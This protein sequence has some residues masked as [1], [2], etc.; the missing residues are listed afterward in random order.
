MKKLAVLLVVALVGCKGKKI[1]EEAALVEREKAAAIEAAKAGKID[2]LA[3]HVG[4]IEGAAF[5]LNELGA[6]AVEGTPTEAYFDGVRSEILGALPESFPAAFLAASD[7][8]AQETILEFIAK[9]DADRAAALKKKLTSR[10]KILVRGASTGS[11]EPLV[12]KYQASHPH[13]RWIVAEGL[14]S[15]DAEAKVAVVLD[16]AEDVDIQKL[17]TFEKTDVSGR[18]TGGPD[19]H[20][21]SGYGVRL[22]VRWVEVKAPDSVD[23]PTVFFAAQKVDQPASFRGS[24]KT[25]A[26]SKFA[27]HQAQALRSASAALHTQLMERFVAELLPKLE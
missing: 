25:S 10:L 17:I 6:D 15:K 2:G 14:R 5:R 12:K 19:Y 27:Q 13:L 21:L 9:A 22:T 16:F 23:E 1:A 20:A 4:M 24:G 26:A 7:K 18:A 11:A 3:Q 8:F